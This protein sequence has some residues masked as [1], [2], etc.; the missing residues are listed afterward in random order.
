M[1]ITE[2][3][4]KQTFLLDKSLAG[5][6]QDSVLKEQLKNLERQI[7]DL[8]AIQIDI[9]PHAQV[10]LSAML[11]NILYILKNPGKTWATATFPIKQQLQWF[12]F[13]EGVL[14]D[15]KKC[16]TTKICSLFNLKSEI[17]PSD[18]LTV[19][20]EKNKSN[21]S[22]IVI[23]PDHSYPAYNTEVFWNNIANDLV[24]LNDIATQINNK[25]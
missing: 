19:D 5:V 17:Y 18:S 21:T 14:F 4:K 12:Y 1:Q 20:L 15:G 8:S 25:D 3:K 23:S 16:Q 11:N 2:I 24:L 22:E 9:T 7:I 10:D 6:I 13:P